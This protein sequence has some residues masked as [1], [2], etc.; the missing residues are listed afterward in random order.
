M[1]KKI[2]KY[3]QKSPINNE[4][5]S[6]I[7]IALIVIAILTFSM[8]TIT[9]V[10]VNLAGST[11][12]KLEQV[13]DE[14]IAKGL[15]N[16]AIS[17]FESFVDSDAKLDEFNNT[18]IA[19]I[20]NDYGIVVTDETDFPENEEFGSDGDHESRI[21]RFAYTLNNGSVLYKF[22]YVSNG[23]TAVENLNP[24]DFSLATNEKL[25]LNSGFY[26]EITL[27]GNEVK[28]SAVAPY[29][30]DGTTTQ[31]VT[32]YSS[33]NGGTYP[34]LTPSSTASL[35]YAS[36]SYTYCSST[37]SCFNLNSGTT[38]IGILESNY[39]NVV[40]SS[41]ND[42]GELATETISDFFSDFS[43]EDFT[44][45]FIKNDAPTS[46]RTI[47]DPMTL[48]TAGDVVRANSDPISSGGGGGG[49]GGFG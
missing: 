25:I 46:N 39:V 49:G 48:V 29:L 15:I 36:D 2:K 37:S 19:R 45:D 13:S 9:G 30:R 41:L 10:N 4:R 34:V 11:N 3:F 27:Y 43:Y 7:S 23:G 21:Y 47:T 1:F 40:G 35:I 38:P 32:P 14:N 26:D 31:Q 5:G 20:L 44:V 22:E 8:T 16:Q 33:S 12:I 18:E 24:F 42:K 6:S 17:E 28:L